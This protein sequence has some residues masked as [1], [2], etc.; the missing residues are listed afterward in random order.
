MDTKEIF[1]KNLELENRINYLDEQ[2]REVNEKRFEIMRKRLHE[3]VFKYTDNYPKMLMVEGNYFCPACGKI[4][5]CMKQ[6]EL[7]KSDFKDSRIIPLTDLSLFGTC[8]VHQIIRDEVYWN[9]KLYYNSK[10][11]V[12]ILSSRM[13]EL[14][15][16]E[17]KVYAN[18]NILKRRK[19]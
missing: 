13:E 2:L 17:E 5:K 1:E 8:T 12:S 18:S 15:K 19:L 14:L 3:I 6:K 11:D 4:I 16:K 9:M 10:I 7:K